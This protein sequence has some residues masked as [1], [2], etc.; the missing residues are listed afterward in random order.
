M[1]VDGGEVSR[2]VWVKVRVDVPAIAEDDDLVLGVLR[3]RKRV[4]CSRHLSRKQDKLASVK[5]EL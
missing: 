3:R 4:D 5:S 2:G 1:R